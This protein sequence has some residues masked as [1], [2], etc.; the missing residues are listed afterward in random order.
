MY[1]IKCRSSITEGMANV[2]MCCKYWLG[3]EEFY[4]QDLSQLIE[5]EEELE[6]DITAE[7]DE[8]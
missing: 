2:I 6:V 1:K 8:K 3:F 7:G 5:A 4:Q